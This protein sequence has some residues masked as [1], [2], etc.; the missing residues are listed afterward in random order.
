[1]CKQLE[2]AEKIQ[3]LALRIIT[4]TKI[5]EHYEMTLPEYFLTWTTVIIY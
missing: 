3:M 5:N 4:M 1:M 2:E